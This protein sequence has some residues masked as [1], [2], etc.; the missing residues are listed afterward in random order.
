MW[1][2]PRGGSQAAAVRD[3]HDR[4]LDVLHVGE[5]VAYLDNTV[6]AIPAPTAR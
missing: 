6:A 4:M 2:D 5:L 1:I 3:R